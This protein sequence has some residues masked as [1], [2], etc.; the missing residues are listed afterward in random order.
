MSEQTMR[1]NVV[2]G[3][4]SLDAVSVETKIEDG[5]PDIN[6]IGGW[7]ECKWLR[8]WPKRE[9]TPVRL[10][11]DLMPHQRAW[12][13]RRWRRGGNAWVLLQVGR[14]WMLYD[15]PTAVEI[16]GKA[17]RK[18]MVDKARSYWQNGLNYQELKHELTKI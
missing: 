17:T 2:H 9:T 1:Q 18:E 14:E 10:D 12:L 8:S 4:R 13:R 6:F 7:I 11:H 16:I 5:I 3:L 15:V